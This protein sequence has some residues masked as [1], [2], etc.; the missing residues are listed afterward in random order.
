MIAARRRVPLVVSAM[1][2][3]L[4]ATNEFVQTL[5]DQHPGGHI[6]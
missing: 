6:S 3:M 1:Q 5:L 2:E 4:M